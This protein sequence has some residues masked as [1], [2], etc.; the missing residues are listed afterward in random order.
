MAKA[1]PTIAPASLNE[2]T[3]YSEEEANRKLCTAF[4]MWRECRESACRRTHR[5]AGDPNACFE[6]LWPRVDEESKVWLRT[7]IRARAAG[8]TVAE[9]TRLGQAEVVRAADHIAYTNAQTL[10]RMAQQR[11]ED[12]EKRKLAPTS[13]STA[14]SPAVRP[15]AAAGSG[16]CRSDPTPHTA[17]RSCS[18]PGRRNP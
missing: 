8:H 14:R 10:K 11:L 17:R 9:A 4:K 18:R 1:K 3:A 5:C 7:A 13:T 15:D 6:R 16:G 2:E 12:E